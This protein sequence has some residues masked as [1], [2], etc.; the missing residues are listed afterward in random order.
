MRS[1]AA[2]TLVEILIVVVILSILAVAVIPQFV[3]ASDDAI[4][5]LA[6]TM[7]QSL[8]SGM[9]LYL[10]HFKKYPAHFGSYVAYSDDGLDSNYVKIGANFRKYLDNPGARVGLNGD[11]QIKLE[12]RN[13]LVATFE[14]P[15]RGLMTATYV[16]P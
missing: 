12:F 14:M 6:L 3:G 11:R 16:D 15:E 10:G 7:E 13:G 9:T 1:W 2:F 5:S 4:K 8:R